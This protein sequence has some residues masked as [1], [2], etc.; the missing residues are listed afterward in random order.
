MSQLA[1]Q[2][3]AYLWFQLHEV[4]RSSSTSP[5][6]G[7]LSMAGLPPAL[8][9]PVPIVHLGGERYYEGEVS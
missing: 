7:C 9:L 2:V 5:W 1:H 8:N 4:T 6:M 3:N